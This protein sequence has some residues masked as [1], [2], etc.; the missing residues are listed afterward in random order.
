MDDRLEQAIRL[1]WSGRLDE[2]EQIYRAILVA[3][4]KQPEALHYLGLARAGR[5][6]LQGAGSLIAQ[7]LDAN[8]ENAETHFHF[9]TILESMG[10]H[11]EAETAFKRAATLA[12]E[13]VE[14]HAGRARLLLALNRAGEAVA[15][16]D[17]LLQANAQFPGARYGRGY[18]LLMARRFEEAIA[19]FD[20][21]PPGMA[22]ALCGRG[23][24]LT[25]LGRREEARASLDRAL[26]LN[27]QFAPALDARSDL[28]FQ[29]VR[30]AEALADAERAVAVAPAYAPAQRSRG[31]AL[32]G[33][34]RFD[35]AYE[36]LSRAI[37]LDPRFTDALN[38]RAEVL[39]ELGR[40]GEALRDA[41][42]SLAID[43]DQ[44]AAHT[45]RGDILLSMGAAEQALTPLDR[46]LELSPDFIIALCARGTAYR[47]LRRLEEARRDFDRVLELAPHFGEVANLRFDV[48]AW[49]CDWR[50][51]AA[52]LGTLAACVRDGRATQP[53]TFL[54]AFDDPE[55]QL[56]AARLCAPPAV[57]AAPFHP[58]AHQ[59][60]RVAYMS[61]DFRDH[62]VAF[63]M[64][65]LFERHDRARFETYG[66]C[67]L[68]SPDSAIRRRV[69]AGLDHFHEAQ[70]RSDAEVAALLASLEID[71]VVDLTGYTISRAR[72]LTRRPAPIAVNYCG[73]AGTLGASFVD[74]ILADG[75]VVPPGAEAFY[76]ERVVRLPGCFFP[77]GGL[78]T[79]PP[80]P[81]RTEAGLP[82]DGVVFCAFNNPYKITPEM[83]DIWMRLLRTVDGSVLWLSLNDQTARENLEREAVARGVEASR[84]VFALRLP[85]REQHFAR[86]QLADLFLDTTPYNAHTTANDALSA[87][88][89]VVTLGGRSFASRVAGSMLSAIGME[90]LVA[91]NVQDY[92][93]LVLEL[94]RSPARR[95]E[96]RAKL[97]RN[98]SMLFDST[99]LC[100]D[101]ERAY[102]TM[103]ETHVAGRTPESFTVS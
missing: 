35:D 90:E 58:R 31:K 40:L 94:A 13:F 55:L 77:S 32:L 96:V 30:F 15:A 20:Q 27:P 7:S 66:I 8:P 24:A 75:F 22:E 103:W 9:A 49:Q 63:Q 83:F 5:G 47:Q 2:A 11:Q 79:L 81:S 62:P 10:R 1:H 3:E 72:V 46:A 98:R 80:A 51:R 18:A 85:E 50:S 16:Y 93:R 26:S 67:L 39:Q 17:R 12:P 41:E 37:S 73:Y 54:A 65:G 92:E 64:A 70:T 84:L 71:I 23:I 28:S 19:D 14:A 59:R 34:I 53:W 52:D 57:P 38:L 76:A 101:I 99:K 95:G 33:L 36:A 4:P 68:S 100:R 29:A 42:H 86:L 43:P 102:E 87:G 74:Y 45:R 97:A 44:A 82:E 89:P 25:A 60:L 88:V 91:R 21:C 78:E 56:A 48:N 61:G 69:K 6:D